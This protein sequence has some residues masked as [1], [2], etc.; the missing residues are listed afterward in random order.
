MLAAAATARGAAARL[1]RRGLVS[2]PKATTGIVGLPVDPNAR[3]KL[4]ALYRETL[5]LAPALPQAG[6]K[7]SVSQIA[8]YRLSVAERTTVAEE[9]EEEIDCGQIEELVEQAEDEL[10]MVKA[11]IEMQQRQPA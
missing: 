3:S 11:V 5:S 4:L 2:A 1:A 9:I 10:G 6:L 8:T 7:D